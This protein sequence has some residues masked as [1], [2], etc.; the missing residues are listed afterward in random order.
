MQLAHSLKVGT[1]AV[2]LG[3]MTALSPVASAEQPKRGGTLNVAVEAE[4]SGFYHTR[5]RIWND[6]TTNGVLPVMETLF[7]FEGEEIVPRLGLELIESDDRMSATVPLRQGVK[8]HDGTPFNADAVV[9]HYNWL[10]DPESGVNTTILAPIESVEKV[11]DYTVRFVLKH[12]WAALNSA[13]ALERMINFIGSPTALE[14]PDTFHRHPVGTGPFVFQEWRS[15]DRMVVTRNEDYWDPQLPYVDRVIYR[16]MPDGDTRFQSMRAGQLDL[17]MVSDPGHILAAGES[18]DLDLYRHTGNGGQSWNF[19]HSKP[20][21]DDPRVRQAVVHAVDGQA[22][23]NAYYRGTTVVTEGLLGSDM[24]SCPDIEWRSYDI[25]KARELAEE[26]GGIKFEHITTNT[27]GGRRLGSMLQ[28]FF[29][30]AGFDATLKTIEQSNNVRTGLSGEYEMDIWRFSDMGGDPD[31][32]LTAYFSTPYVT[33][34]NAEPYEELLSEARQE[35]DF[36]RRRELYCQV[37]QLFADDA[38]LLLP[39]RLTF[40]AIGQPHV[41]GVPPVMNNLIRVRS[42]WI[43]K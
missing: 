10:M 34:H 37:S 32:I 30:E 28:H 42:A 23:V 19:N 12:P 26:V 36:E 15:G 6:N 35:S 25:D 7:V 9:H 31:H 4:F 13:L 18:K 27:P 20:P 29:T 22:L 33:R 39:V 16:I 24:W 21:F 2:V 14:D 41:K 3:A 8:F 1:V 17:A 11:D 40:S 38:T 5:A 43:D